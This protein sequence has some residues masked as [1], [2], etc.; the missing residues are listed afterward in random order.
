MITNVLPRF[1]MNHSANKITDC[2]LMNGTW[3]QYS[4][5]K[6]LKSRS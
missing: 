2:V 3:E 5:V 6:K 4:K 1:F